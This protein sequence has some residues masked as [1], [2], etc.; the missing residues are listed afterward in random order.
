MVGLPVI[1][2][3]SLRDE[4]PEIAWDQPQ[5]ITITGGE[6]TSYYGWLCR[7]C[8]ALKGLRA[9]D[10]LQGNPDA[11]VWETREEA[12]GHIALFHHD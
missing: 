12:L 4:F 5:R 1:D 10:V 11:P 7:Y 3:G 8:V 2:E 9:V 6:G